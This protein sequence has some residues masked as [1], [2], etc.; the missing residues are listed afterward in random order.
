MM[1]FSQC[2]KCNRPALHINGN[3]PAIVAEVAAM[4]EEHMG[5]K[6][7]PEARL[8]DMAT[9]KPRLDS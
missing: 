4:Y 5:L 1:G 6:N 7:P 2:P 3:N 9:G 8:T